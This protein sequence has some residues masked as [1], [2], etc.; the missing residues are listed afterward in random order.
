[1]PS[2]F[3][4]TSLTSRLKNILTPNQRRLHHLRNLHLLGVPTSRDPPPPTPHPAHLL[5]DKTR[6][7]P[8]RAR[9][10]HRLRRAQR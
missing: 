7:H 9:S 2:N 10:R 1:M 6:F 3:H 5:L 8:S 4:V